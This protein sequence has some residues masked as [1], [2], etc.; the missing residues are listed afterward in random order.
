MFFMNLRGML[1][2][3]FF[4]FLL[5]T[6]SS[7]EMRKASIQNIA[8]KN[9]FTAE[10][11]SGKDFQVQTF[12]KNINNKGFARIYLEGDGLVLNSQGFVTENPTPSPAMAL[13]LMAMDSSECIKIAILRP[14]QYV[15]DEA[16][17]P[18]YW[19]T[20]RYHPKV[21]QAVLHTIKHYQ[22]QLKF[23]EFEVVAYSGGASIIN[24][25]VSNY[26]L[27]PKK[28]TT[29]AGNLDHQEWTK[30]HNFQPLF[31]SS[32][33]D[34]F[35]NIALIPQTHFVGKKD[36]LTTPELAHSFCKKVNSSLCQVKEIPNY[37]HADCWEKIWLSEL[38]QNA[39]NN[40]KKPI[41]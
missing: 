35:K 7:V 23:Q 10:I 9:N 5:T 31:E 3:P 20:G 32:L 12:I 25:L 15:S 1:S 11:V 19:T 30:H 16:C 14:C 2:I 33:I 40:N 26:N 41:E 36:N 22:N 39:S 8:K 27:K 29:F 28:I 4:L 34:N 38:G 13:K 24:L 17:Q 18:L 6:C 37:E 21:L